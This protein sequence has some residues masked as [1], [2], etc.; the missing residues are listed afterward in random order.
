MPRPVQSN[1]RERETEIMAK[2][3][4]EMAKKVEKTEDGF[5]PIPAGIYHAV[6]MKVDTDKAGPAGPYWSWEFSVI[7]PAE[8]TGRK[9]WNNTTLKEGAMF[10]LKQTFEAFGVGTDADTDD[11]CGKVVKLTVGTRIIPSGAREGEEANNI[12]RVMP[13]D[14]GITVNTGSS[15]PDPEDVFGDD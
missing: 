15:S 6:L 13:P 7:D 11:L 10:G 1:G 12:N 14:E 5:K 2:L 9:L 8:Y 4:K 3:N